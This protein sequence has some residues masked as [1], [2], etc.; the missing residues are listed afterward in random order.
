MSAFGLGMFDH[1]LRGILGK[2]WNKPAEKNCSAT[3]TGKLGD[4]E[5]GSIGRPDTGKRIG[6]GPR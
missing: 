5:A 1:H 2:R 6:G 3:G 4:N